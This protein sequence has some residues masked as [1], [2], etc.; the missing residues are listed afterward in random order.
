MTNRPHRSERGSGTIHM[1]TACLLVATALATAVLWA[2]ISTARH[3][4]GAAADMTALS[5]AYALTTTP[6]VAAARAAAANN[7]ELTTCTATA[8]DVTV[9]VSV[10]LDLPFLPTQTLTTSA[11]AG[12]TG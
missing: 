4:L 3:K 1:L 9:Q 2:A 5:A 8:D 11:R 10:P 12:P 7:A 6:C